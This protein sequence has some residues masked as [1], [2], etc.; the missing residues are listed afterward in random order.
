MNFNFGGNKSTT[1]ATKP[2]TP[3]ATET[4][5][6]PTTAPT[7]PAAPP[8][9]SFQNFASTA[10]PT[11]GTPESKSAARAAPTP[12]E[13]HAQRILDAGQS[14]PMPSDTA[15]AELIT[16]FETDNPLPDNP[17]P[18]DLLKHNLDKLAIIYHSY[19][20]G[21]DTLKEIH[22]I[23]RDTPD[24]KSILTPQ[25]L[26][27]ISQAMATLTATARAKEARTATA[28]PARRAK[29]AEKSADVDE[30]SALGI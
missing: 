27:S 4:T 11:P 9:S 24:L 10:R 18:A 7:A 1:P 23:L 6:N 3:P 2:S 16:Q 15:T 26:G 30:I 5:T 29:K 14:T 13:Q 28:A 12:R 21:R 20:L 25:S 22:S 19:N 17:Q 8:T